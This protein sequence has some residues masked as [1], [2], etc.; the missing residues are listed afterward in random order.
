MVVEVMSGSRDKYE[1]KS[2]LEAFVLDHI[3]PS[4]LQY[5]SFE[6]G[7]VRGALKFSESS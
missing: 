3:I 7:F 6:Y 2:K 4:R 1:Y 5:F